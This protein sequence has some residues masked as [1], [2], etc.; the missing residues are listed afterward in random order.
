MVDNQESRDAQLDRGGVLKELARFHAELTTSVDAI[1][2]AFHFDDR[3][4]VKPAYDELMRI[5]DR[6][7]ELPE[8]LKSLHPLFGNPGAAGI[9]A[10]SQLIETMDATMTVLR[11][12]AVGIDRYHG[13]AG[14]L[15]RLLSEL[16]VAIARSGE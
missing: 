14:K 3:G 5:P 8:K 1:D 12:M 4:A 13:L 6:H 15:S 2:A 11:D 16:G 7:N 9:V 10:H